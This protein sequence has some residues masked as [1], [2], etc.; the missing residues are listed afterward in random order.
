MGQVAVFTGYGRTSSAHNLVASNG[1][2][3]HQEGLDPQ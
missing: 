1:D 3:A 2:S